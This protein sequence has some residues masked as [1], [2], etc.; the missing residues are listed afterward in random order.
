MAPLVFSWSQ[1]RPNIINMLVTQGF[2]RVS[3]LGQK[4]FQFIKLD[5]EFQAQNS[6]EIRKEIRGKKLSDLLFVETE[7]GLN[8]CNYM[9]TLMKDY[10]TA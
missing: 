8:P 4:R 1:I 5:L 9:V 10:N 3:S 2:L 7:C 6:G